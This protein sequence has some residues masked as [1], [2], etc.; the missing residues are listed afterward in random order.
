VLNGVHHGFVRVCMK[1]EPQRTATKC[2]H[3]INT[4]EYI[5]LSRARHVQHISRANN[6]LRAFA[7][8]IYVHVNQEDKQG[9]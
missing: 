6:S 8:Y 5:H 4:I 7:R 9:R 2:F 3:Q 1:T